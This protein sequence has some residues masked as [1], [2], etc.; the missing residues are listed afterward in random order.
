MAARKA[1]GAPPA[2][3]PPQSPAP[4]GREEAER[5]DGPQPPHCPPPAP[6]P[7]ARV[8]AEWSA[9]WLWWLRN[10]YPGWHVWQDDGPL[11][12][13][14]A[15]RTIGFRQGDQPDD[16]RYA[17]HDTMPEGL[18]GQLAAQ[19]EVPVPADVVLP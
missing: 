6:P 13:W 11:G 2:A 9:Q 5:E 12:A 19:A 18:A 1:L 10:A 4:P 16:P 3:A 7:I 8:L 14:H 17:L 15:R